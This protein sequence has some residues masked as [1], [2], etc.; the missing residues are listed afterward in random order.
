VLSFTDLYQLGT[1]HTQ[2][3]L[4]VL[5]LASLCLAGNDDTG[6]MDQSNCRGCFVDVLTTGTGG[7]EDLHLI[8][9]RL[10]LK[11]FTVVLDLGN[12]FNGSKGGLAAGIGIKGRYTDQAVNTV[13]SLQ[14]AIGIL[15]FDDDIGRFQSCLIA[16]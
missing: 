12:H 14:E 4:L 6:F 3:G 8:V 1:E 7:T 10:D 5:E 15:T 16:S 9:F 11:I 13:L 2:A